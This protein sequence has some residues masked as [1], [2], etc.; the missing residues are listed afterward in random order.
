MSKKTIL[1]L[2]AL[3]LVVGVMA[4][5]FVLTRPDTQKGA[6]EIV[7]VVNHADGSSVPFVYHTDEEYLGALLLSEKLIEGYEGQFG[8]VIE[9][10]D[11][12]AATWD[13]G[14]WWAF[15]LNEVKPEN[16]AVVAVSEQVIKDGDLFIF[17]YEKF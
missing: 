17:N 4:A 12:E 14:V 16:L 8:F 6:K 11:G 13:N 3:I 10:V 7:V 15:Y 5:V 9:K 2:I 1:A